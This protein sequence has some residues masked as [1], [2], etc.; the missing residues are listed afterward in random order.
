MLDGDAKKNEM[1]ISNDE[2]ITSGIKV[3]EKKKLNA[4]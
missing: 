4:I 3:Y 1:D 2:R